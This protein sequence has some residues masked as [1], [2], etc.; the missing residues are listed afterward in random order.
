MRLDDICIKCDNDAI[1]FAEKHPVINWARIKLPSL[2]EKKHDI[3]F[4]G[5]IW[6]ESELVDGVWK[7][8]IG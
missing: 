2:P 6:I 1:S 8:A 3:F 4:N 5:S 7:M